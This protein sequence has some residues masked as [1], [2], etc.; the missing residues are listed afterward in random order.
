MEP[1]SM[2]RTLSLAV[3]LLCI[4]LPPAFV[5]VSGASD[6]A[7][8]RTTGIIRL[9]GDSR[10]YIVHVPPSHSGTSPVALVLSLH[11]AATWPS[12]QKNLTEWNTLADRDGFIVAYPSG[13]GVWLR[14]FGLRDTAFIVALIDKLESIYN[15]DSDR[16]YVNG[17]SNGGGMSYALSCFLSGRIAAVGAVA[18]AI[19]MSADLCPTAKPIP[20][21]VFHGTADRFTRWEG[22]KVFI[23]PTPFPAI[24]VWAANWAR[25]NH[26]AATQTE[27][28]VARDVTRL[29]YD[30]CAA[31]VIVYKIDDGGHTWPGGAELPQWFA[32]RTTHTINATELMWSFFKDHPLTH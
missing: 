23:A 14:A 31:P 9:G 20:V 24:P 26:C 19:T 17:L 10:E 7:D 21:M 1:S 2:T 4:G 22:G 30:H 3:V 13:A 27:S 8:N 11:G 12:L 6:Y 32:G 28:N 25:R 15:I 5:L 18:P 29:E 16:I